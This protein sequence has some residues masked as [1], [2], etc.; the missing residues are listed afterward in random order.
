MNVCLNEQVNFI[1][2]RNLRRESPEEWLAIAQQDGMCCEER[3]GKRVYL[4]AMTWNDK[5]LVQPIRAVYHVT[6]RTIEADG[7][8][9]LTPT[10][11]AEVY[12]T[13][14]VCEYEQ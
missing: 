14:L 7:Q 5:K 4:G 1:I 11:D 3:E 12:W 6:E 2:K 13:T 10:V 9:L 8:I